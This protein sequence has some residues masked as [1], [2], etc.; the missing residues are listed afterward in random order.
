VPPEQSVL[1]R[2]LFCALTQVSARGLALRRPQRLTELERTTGA[3]SSQLSAAID[4]LRAD[5]VSFLVLR[6]DP[7][8]DWVDIGHEAL[9]RCWTAL[10]DSRSGWIQR[11]LRDGLRWRALLVQAEAFEAD[12]QSVLSEAATEAQQAW[13]TSRREAWAD[14]YGGG[15]GRVRQLIEASLRA[16][17]ALREERKKASERERAAEQRERRGRRL[18]TALVAFTTVA[19]VLAVVIDRYRSRQTEEKQAQNL[20]LSIALREAE[21]ERERLQRTNV[22]LQAVAEILRNASGQSASRLRGQVEVAAEKLGAL[23]ET[24]ASVPPRVYLHISEPAQRPAAE[25]L[26]RKVGEIRVGTGNPKLAVVAPGV[27]LVPGANVPPALRCFKKAECAGTARDLLKQLNERLETPKLQLQ[28]LSAR[29]END[30]KL[31][32]HH[33][34]VWFGR[35]AVVVAG[36]RSTATT[37]MAARPAAV[38]ASEVLPVKP[39]PRL[40]PLPPVPVVTPPPPAPTAPVQAVSKT[41]PPQTLTATDRARL[42]VFR[43]DKGRS[44]STLS[45]AKT[46]GVREWTWASREAERRGV[47]TALGVALVFDTTISHGERQARTLDKSVGEQGERA[48]ALDYLRRRERL[49]TKPAREE[50]RVAELRRLVASNEL[51]LDKETAALR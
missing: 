41:P 31:R 28:D 16:R 50:Q 23:A 43:L 15:Y 7:L 29:Y 35:G 20:E 40:I 18:L 4:A 47:K 34:E 46:L 30:E 32:P 39:E 13:L 27:E 44:A 45:E 26:Q 49:T 21:L 36:T 11:E 6:P 24:V 33:Y 48:W 38:A 3:D 17:D 14:R 8:G 19:V 25:D 9:I 5:G 22:E 12:D 1:L 2:E 42:L 37:V 51:S 10:S